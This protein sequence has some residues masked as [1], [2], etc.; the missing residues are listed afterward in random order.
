[1]NDD[2]ISVIEA[3]REVGDAFGASNRER[4][5]LFD[6]LRRIHDIAARTGHL[7][8]FVIYGSFVT[9]K[10]TPNDVDAS[11]FSTIRSMLRLAM[12]R[13]RCFSITRLR[14]R[15]L[16]RACSGFVGLLPLVASRLQLNSGRQNAMVGNEDSSESWRR[17]MISNDNELSVT[18]ARIRHLQDQL[19][20][21]RKTEPNSVNYRLSS[22]GFIAEIDRMQ[23]EVREYLSTPAAI[24]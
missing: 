17:Q 14:I 2:R 10:L 8:R 11:W 3:A 22:S 9:G 24:T 6:R 18:L 1:M 19:A 4:G 13:H 12:L 21:L 16:A 15:I 20:L 23:L 7:A 5:L